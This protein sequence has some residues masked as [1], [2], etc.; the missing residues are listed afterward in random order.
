M[1]KSLSHTDFSTIETSILIGLKKY[2]RNRT[3]SQIL[4]EARLYADSRER[5]EAAFTLEGAGY[6]QS[7]TYQLPVTI[8]AELSTLG[9]DV[10]DSLEVDDRIANN[11]NPPTA[12]H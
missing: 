3:F 11:E 6:I 7:V 12:I 1:T 10:A 2:G 4:E 8:R 5:V 9:R